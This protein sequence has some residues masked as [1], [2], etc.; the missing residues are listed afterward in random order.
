MNVTFRW[1]RNHVP[2]CPLGLVGHVLPAHMREGLIRTYQRGLG[3]AGFFF[4]VCLLVLLGCGLLLVAVLISS[5]PGGGNSP[6]MGIWRYQG[7][8]ESSMPGTIA[9]I[10]LPNLQ[11]YDTY[12]ALKLCRAH[13]GN[14]A[15]KQHET[16]FS[17]SGIFLVSRN[18]LK[19]F[20]E[21]MLWHLWICRARHLGLFLNNHDIEDFNV[22]GFLTHE[23]YALDADARFSGG[24][25]A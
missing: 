14:N 10:E 21:K 25:W 19:K 5:E 2:R 17:H 23:D 6:V 9:L 22:C 15:Q 11:S 4:S 20:W 7:V 3:M 16:S 8:S 12:P 13:R 24:C 18:H 1:I